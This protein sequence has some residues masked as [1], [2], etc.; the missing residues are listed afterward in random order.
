MASIREMLGRFFVGDKV[1]QLNM[2]IDI[3]EHENKRSNYL[4]SPQFLESQLKELD[5]HLFDFILRQVSSFDTM[6]SSTMI[7][8]QMRVALVN[9]C[10]L[11]NVR[12]P[13]TQSIV[14]MWTDFGFGTKVSIEVMDKD[15]AK[16]WEK[17]WLSPRNR[18]ILGIRNITSLS[19]VLLTDGEL[20]LVFFIAKQGNP[21]GECTIG[22]IP[23]EQILEI[24]YDPQSTQSPVYY[25][26]QYTNTDSL[27]VT[28][29]YKD[30]L[31]SP[32]QVIRT[33]AKIDQ[34]DNTAIYAETQNSQTDVKVI[35]AAFRPYNNR[36]YPLMTAGIDW[37]R[38]YG[39]FLEDRAAVAKLV[40]TYVD[41]LKI[42]GGSRAV[43]AVKAR[44][45]S[46]L[47]N[48]GAAL[49]TNPPPPAASEWVE[50]E[51]MT[52]ERM[53]LGT[54]AS[55]AE[56]DGSMLLSQATLAGRLFPS[57]LGAGGQA[58]RLSSMTTMEKPVMRAFNSYQLFWSS[59]WEDMS[60][61]VFEAAEDYNGLEF[62]SYK[63]RVNTDHI[64]TMDVDQISNFMNAITN[65]ERELI[66]NPEVATASMNILIKNGLESLGVAY[67]D[68]IFDPENLGQTKPSIPRDE[69][70]GLETES[71]F[72][73]KQKTSLKRGDGLMMNTLPQS[74]RMRLLSIMQ[75][76]QKRN[77]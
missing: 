63:I 68:T 42:K 73:G 21:A 1:K 8:E 15:A 66:V 9:Q 50:N 26:R 40:S 33:R 10:R 2:A 39:H 29:Y 77:G 23:T 28:M 17:F 62:T 61:L 37:S 74:S 75:N 11:M 24:I 38:A 47:I 49:D 45:S 4:L 58:Y 30:W 32:E 13:V 56:K 35:H 67:M 12:D 71:F 41:K 25:K 70:A 64:I 76:L 55:D 48:P 6:Y 51:A 5:P 3:L 72:T 14:G 46:A 7:S 59:I 27:P 20:F 69:G 16:I 54:G 43:D 52:R 53:P 65:G 60:T 18:H 19:T 36:G 22:T 34:T 44:L 57:Y 31:A